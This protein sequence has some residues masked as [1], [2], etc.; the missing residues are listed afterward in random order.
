MKIQ[1]ASDLHLEFPENTW[2]LIDNPIVPKADILLLA[3][4]IVTFVHQE[5]ADWFFDYVSKNFKQTYWVPGNHEYYHSDI[6]R[7]IGMFNVPIR[8]NVHL[9]NNISIKHDDVNF[10]FSTLW[11]KIHEVNMFRI[12]RGMSDYHVIRDG[13]E[14]L[15]P[16]KT[17]LFFEENIAFITS[18]L[19]RLQDEKTVVVTHHIPTLMNYP[20]QFKGDALM[21]GFAVELFDMIE[22]LKPNAW[23]YGH[24][25]HSKP[26]FQI[27]ETILLNNALGYV[28]SEKTKYQN[29]QTIQ[30]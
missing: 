16:R 22:E 6:N 7:H 25:H 9:V 29:G 8:K 19:K 3:G 5:K 4:D 30:V 2:F 26:K 10:I 15:H 18:E 17:T 11:T 24:S 21:E 27:E 12:E 14:I 13:D 28:R 23:I 1:Y 20:E